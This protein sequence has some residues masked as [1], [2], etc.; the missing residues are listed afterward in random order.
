MGL[1]HFLHRVFLI[2]FSLI[3]DWIDEP[4]HL[5]DGAWTPT[6]HTPVPFT[7]WVIDF[8]LIKTAAWVNNNI[9]I[10]EIWL[11]SVTCKL[12]QETSNE[13]CD[14]QLSRWWQVKPSIDYLKKEYVIIW[15]DTFNL[16]ILLCYISQLMQTNQPAKGQNGNLQTAVCNMDTP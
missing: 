14:D 12:C 4:E 16:S 1:Q 13:S 7:G 5:G 6:Q 15:W 2:F 10:L 8:P 11:Q 9:P 3:C